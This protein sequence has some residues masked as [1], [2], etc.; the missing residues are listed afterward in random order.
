MESS[1]LDGFLTTIKGG[2][3]DFSVANLGTIIVAVLGVTVGLV[4]AWFAYNFIKRKVS[5]AM[6]KG[7]L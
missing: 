5:S 7:R 3:G 6:K 2:L 1:G 4:I